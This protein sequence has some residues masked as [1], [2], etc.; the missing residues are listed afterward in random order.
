[1]G[2]IV[3]AALSFHQQREY[4]RSVPLQHFLFCS[5]CHA[6]VSLVTSKAGGGGGHSGMTLKTPDDGPGAD[7]PRC[8]ARTTTTCYSAHALVSMPQQLF[9]STSTPIIPNTHTLVLSV[10]QPSGCAV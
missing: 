4:I 6:I 8:S 10:T 1:M 9:L 2:F 5:H 3:D 7:A